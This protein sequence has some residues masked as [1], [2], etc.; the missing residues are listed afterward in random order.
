MILLLSAW[1]N[2]YKKSPLMSSRDREGTRPPGR[3][4]WMKSTVGGMSEGTIVP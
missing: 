1:V 4:Y 3:R 2:Y